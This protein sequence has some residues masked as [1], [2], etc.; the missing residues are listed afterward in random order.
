MATWDDEISAGLAPRLRIAHLLCWTAASALGFAAYRGITPS[1][2][3]GSPRVYLGVYDSVMGLALGTILT[4]VGIMAYRRWRRDALS[5]LAGAL[6]LDT[7]PR[8]RGRRRRGDR[9]LRIPHSPL[10]PALEVASGTV[11]LPKV[12]L[13]QFLISKNP[14]VIGVYHQAFGWESEP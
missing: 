3:P 7:R 13:I 10:L 5:L 9:C 1:L 8:R 11:N 12:L 2:G 6:A 4:G 14:D